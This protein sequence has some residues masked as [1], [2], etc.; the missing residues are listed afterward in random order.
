MHT[1]ADFDP[2]ETTE[3]FFTI[4]NSLN[5]FDKTELRGILKT[6]IGEKTDREICYLGLYYRAVANIETVLLLKSARKSRPSQ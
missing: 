1:D 3:R 2:V 4:I 6:L 5:Q